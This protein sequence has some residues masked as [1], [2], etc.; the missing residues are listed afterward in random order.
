[1]SD[2]SQTDRRPRVHRLR[3]MLGDIAETRCGKA[4]TYQSRQ[5][6]MR[7]LAGKSTILLA[8]AG[9]ALVTCKRCRQAAR[10]RCT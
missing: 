4:G 7:L 1:M 5:V 6:P 2:V 8:T 9:G 10:S 3:R